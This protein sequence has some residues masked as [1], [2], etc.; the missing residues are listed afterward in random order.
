MELKKSVKTGFTHST[1]IYQHYIDVIYLLRTV[2]PVYKPVFWVVLC[3]Y[4]NNF[5]F[6]NWDKRVY[7]QKN[8]RTAL[9]LLFHYGLVLINF[10]AICDHEFN[11]KTKDGSLIL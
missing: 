9:D 6:F 3:N 10:P 11:Q 4:F 8:G 7:C 1:Q 5:F 2:Q